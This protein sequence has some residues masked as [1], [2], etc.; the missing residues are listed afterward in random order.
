MPG[1]EG[2]ERLRDAERAVRAAQEAER[3]A[4]AG[5]RDA[6]SLRERMASAARELEVIR[7]RNHFSEL[8][9]EAVRRGYGPP[10]AH[11]GQR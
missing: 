11:G 10:P 6:A 4:D 1:G 8:V 3:A 9:A 2:G 5:L 7:S